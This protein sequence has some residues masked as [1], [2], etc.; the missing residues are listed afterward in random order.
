MASLPQR[1]MTTRRARLSRWLVA[2]SGLGLA[3]GLVVS[4]PARSL[5]QAGAPAPVPGAVGAVAPKASQP[6]EASQPPA[7]SPSP[8][9]SHEPNP[10]R[11]PAGSLAPSTA[12]SPLAS[13]PTAPMATARPSRGGDRFATPESRR[14]LQ[15]RLDD[16]RE[17]YAIPGISV[18]IIFPDG[19]RWVGSSGLADVKAGR[20]VTPTTKFAVASVSKTFTAALIMALEEDG[21]V[22]LDAT[23]RS[24]LPE[25]AIDPAIT[26]RQLLD[27]TSGLNDFFFD[28]RIDKTLLSQPARRWDPAESLTYVGKPYFKPGR[29][30]HYS[31]TNYLVLGML[32]ERAGG[33][34]LSDQLHERFLGPLGLAE[35]SYQPSDEP[36][37]PLAHGYR[38]AS[39]GRTAR[40]IDLSDGSGIAP[41]TSV[42]TAAAGAG[43]IASNSQDLAVWTRQLYGGHVLEPASLQAMILD[44]AS[45][46]RFRPRLPYGL[47][48]QLIDFAGEPS[49][50]HSGRLL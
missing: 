8:E 41:F 9:A 36:A 44:A 18:T 39:P 38:F 7:A 3:F 25:L 13:S 21:K 1:R 42:V 27:H 35:T 12:P 2:L 37:D 29:G 34:P 40:P 28:R 11:T 20:Q 19:T 24:Y 33:A 10:S 50:G 47:G 49:L 30:W 43:G 4:G 17:R 46:A 31:N 22:A 16:L 23:V 48:V 6:P 45:T 26:V 15:A 14:A 5:Q 32:A